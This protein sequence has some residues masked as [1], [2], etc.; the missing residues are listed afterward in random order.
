MNKKTIE[1]QNLVAVQSSNIGMVGYDEANLTTYVQFKNGA[2]Y[3]YPKTEPQEYE[4]LSKANS[5]GSHFAKTYKSKQDFVKLED[6]V[7]TKAKLT[8][9]QLEDKVIATLRQFAEDKLQDV[10]TGV[11]RTYAKD[12]ITLVRDNSETNR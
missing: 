8:Q 1:L 10:T 6:V 11:Q 9:E 2:I 7:L 3:S 12:L 5:V 4:A